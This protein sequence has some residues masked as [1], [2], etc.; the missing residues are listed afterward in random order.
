[1]DYGLN[2]FVLNVEKLEVWSR[3]IPFISCPNNHMNSFDW[4]HIKCDQS[5]FWVND[6][7]SGPIEAIIFLSWKSRCNFVQFWTSSGLCQ[8]KLRSNSMRRKHV[9]HNVCYDFWSQY[10]EHVCHVCND[11]KKLVTRA[12]FKRIRSELIQSMRATFFL[13]ST[14]SES[15]WLPV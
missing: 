7:Q 13:S 2:E 8:I 9:F 14:F 4:T 1:M 5:G 6:N 10:Q 12:L 3:S 11:L 15:L